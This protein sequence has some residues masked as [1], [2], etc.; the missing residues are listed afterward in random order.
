[1]EFVPICLECENFERGDKCKYF[2]KIPDEIKLRIKRCKWYSEGEYEL[3]LAEG[4]KI[5]N[6]NRR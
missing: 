5:A 2:P 4:N 3:F 1:M 6:G